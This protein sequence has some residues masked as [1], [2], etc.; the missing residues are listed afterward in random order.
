[1]PVPYGFQVPTQYLNYHAQLQ[2]W[3]DKN[4]VPLEWQLLQT[5]FE[6]GALMHSVYPTS[7]C[8]LN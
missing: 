7:G 1:M 2:E 3:A 5:E 4:H 8:L 6:N